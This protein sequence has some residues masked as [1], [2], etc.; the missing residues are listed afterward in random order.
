MVLGGLLIGLLYHLRLWTLDGDGL[1]VMQ[2]RSPYWDF[3]NLWAGSGMALDG[4]VLTL[5][6]AEAYRAALRSLFGQGLP[7]Q[8][9]SYPPG[10]LLAGLPLALLPIAAAYLVWTF[11][12]VAALGLALRSLTLPPA[13][14]AALLVSPAVI[15]NALL[16]QNGALTAA[17]LVGGLCMTPSRPVLAGV[18]FGLLTIKPHLG[19]LV[20]FCLIAAGSWRAIAAAA[21]TAVATIAV[22]GLM[23]GLEPW[24]LFFTETAPLMR[25]IMEAPYPQHYHANAMT[26]FILARSAGADLGIA[27]LVQGAAAC[28][29]AAAVV[30]LWMPSTRVDHAMKVGTTAVLALVATPYGYSYDSIPMCVAIAIVFLRPRRPPLALLA[31]AWLY[32]LVAHLPN[33]YGYGVGILVPVALAGW[34]LADARRESLANDDAPS[35]PELTTV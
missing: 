2:G 16:G 30:W 25:A 4:Q 17:L 7:D 32:P 18:L 27:Y 35:G 21:A 20:P 15:I 31:L 34:M 10:V 23:F 1:S 14:V 8:E 6:D 26:V 13:A 28:A 19:I 11:G 22:T 12:T 9:W 24:V 33:F 5:F 29:S 3:T